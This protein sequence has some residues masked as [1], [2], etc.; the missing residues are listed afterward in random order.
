MK[1]RI[2]IVFL[3]G[4]EM[5]DLINI[6]FGLFELV[7]SFNVEWIVHFLMLFIV[8]M[9]VLIVNGFPLLSGEIILVKVVFFFG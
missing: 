9:V 1:I 2:R 3:G 5:L 4:F 7:N 6:L 8:E